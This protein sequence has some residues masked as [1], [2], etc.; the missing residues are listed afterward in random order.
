MVVAG[1]EREVQ[2]RREDAKMQRSTDAE[3]RRA[4]AEQLEKLGRNV[5]YGAPIKGRTYERSVRPRPSPEGRKKEVGRWISGAGWD[6]S[7]SACL[8]VSWCPVSVSPH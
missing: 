4:A 5:G 6:V 2:K 3:M 7:L 8:V 1:A